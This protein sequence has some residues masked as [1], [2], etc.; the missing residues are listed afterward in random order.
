MIIGLNTQRRVLKTP[1]GP[2]PR[3]C[4]SRATGAREKTLTLRA[5]IGGAGLVLPHGNADVLEVLPP[6]GVALALQTARP[7]DQPAL[8]HP[9]R[10]V[11]A[12]RVCGR[13]RDTAA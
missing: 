9:L 5:A 1:T 4:P 7:Q 10:Q 11:Q 6:L 3:P 12:A 8:E 2:S 13:R